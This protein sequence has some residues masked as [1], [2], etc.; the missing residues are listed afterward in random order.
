M[1]AQLFGQKPR[2][3]PQ[4]LARRGYHV[5]YRAGEANRCPGCGR[6]HWYVGR[7]SA[8]CGFCGTALPLTEG[9]GAGAGLFRSRGRSNIADFA[10]AA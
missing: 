4:M 2:A 6:S 5:V 7:L 9:L 1:S 3:F 8:E 10:N